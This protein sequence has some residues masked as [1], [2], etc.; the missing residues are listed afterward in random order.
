MSAGFSYHEIEQV[1]PFPL[2]LQTIHA[3]M[4][5]TARA[6]GASGALFRWANVDEGEKASI[7]SKFDKIRDSLKPETDPD[8]W[9]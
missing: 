7:R 6:A 8:E 1:I 2:L 9:H 3:H 4:L 5:F